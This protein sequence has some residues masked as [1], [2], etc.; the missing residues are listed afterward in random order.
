VDEILIAHTPDQVG[1]RGLSGLKV[2]PFL[3]DKFLCIRGEMDRRTRP[4]IRNWDIRPSEGHFGLHHREFGIQG[5]GYFPMSK[6][7]TPL[8][9]KG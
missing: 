2:K 1:P 5:R 9:G 3:D 8:K 4:E 7:H 6:D